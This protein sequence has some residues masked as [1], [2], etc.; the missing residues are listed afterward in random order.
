MAVG[1]PY[2]VD[3]LAAATGRPVHDLLAELATLEI[4]GRVVRRSGSIFVRT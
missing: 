1:E 3:E 4:A 2:S